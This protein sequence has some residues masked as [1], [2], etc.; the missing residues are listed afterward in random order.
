MKHLSIAAISVI[1]AIMIHCMVQVQQMHI[2]L[3]R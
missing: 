3:H 2:I 1:F